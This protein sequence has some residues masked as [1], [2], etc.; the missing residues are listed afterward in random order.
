MRV[1]ILAL[2]LNEIEGCKAILPKIKRE[3]A[4]QFL[5]V[6]GGSTDGTQEYAASQGWQVYEQQKPGIRFA[7]SESWP[8]ITGDIVVIISPDGNTPVEKIPEMLAQFGPGI[9]R[10]VI[11][12]RYLNAESD[13]DTWYTAIGNKLFN[14]AAWILYGWEGT[15]CMTIFRAMPQQLYYHINLH[16]DSAYEYAERLFRTVLSMEPLSTIRC[17]KAGI[18]IIEV[19]CGEPARIGGVTK[20]QTFRWAA[21][22]AL[23]FITEKFKWM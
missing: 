9:A 4:D 10:M 23:Q 18:P 6:D 15:D 7:Y 22:Y 13:D 12:S 16:E 2:T 8:L 1:T 5:L 19:S 11:G 17:L 3:W 20:R 21:G 14:W